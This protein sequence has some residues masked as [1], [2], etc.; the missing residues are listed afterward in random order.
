MFERCKL[1]IA[2]NV[3]GDGIKPVMWPD[4]SDADA[5]RDL[6]T[7]AWPFDVTDPAENVVIASADTQTDGTKVSFYVYDLN[8]A[9][10]HKLK[11]ELRGYDLIT[12]Q[13]TVGGDY[14]GMDSSEH[15]ASVIFVRNTKDDRYAIHPG[16]DIRRYSAST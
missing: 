3:M 2:E 4:E 15:D 8:P 6:E 13:E 1:K 5:W 16:R 12:W 11:R 10:K 9:E 7:E 14:Q